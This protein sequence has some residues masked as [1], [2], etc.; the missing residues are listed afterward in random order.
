[1]DAQQG[2]ARETICHRS[3]SYTQDL[4][5][6]ERAK[7]E[8]GLRGAEKAGGTSLLAVQSAQTT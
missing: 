6:D 2:A 5:K 1:M 8:G 3:L 7:D 4:T